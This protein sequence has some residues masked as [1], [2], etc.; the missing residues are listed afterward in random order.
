MQKAN[1]IAE[2]FFKLQEMNVQYI[3]LSV[4]LILEITI[5]DGVALVA[6]IL[7]A[8]SNVDTIMTVKTFIQNKNQELFYLLEAL[9]EEA[10]NT[11]LGLFEE[12]Y[13]S[14]SV[15]VYKL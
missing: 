11:S 6:D 9:S 7:I 2:V 3:L 5:A 10:E 13:R 14:F 15:L 4:Y 1:L 12:V 8:V